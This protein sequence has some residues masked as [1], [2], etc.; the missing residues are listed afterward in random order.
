[1]LCVFFKFRANHILSVEGQRVML[2]QN[3]QKQYKSASKYGHL[4]VKLQLSV[5]IPGLYIVTESD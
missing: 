1:M 3:Q 2:S 5:N 4:D